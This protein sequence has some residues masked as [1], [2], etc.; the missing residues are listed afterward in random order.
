MI[1][2]LAV[3]FVVVA[4]VGLFDVPWDLVGPLLPWVA[5]VVVLWAASLFVW[6]EKRCRNCGGKGTRWGPFKMARRCGQC[7][8]TGRVPRLFS[9]GQ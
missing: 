3:L 7:G 8:G 9:K 4:I 1:A 2:L 5:G 6:P